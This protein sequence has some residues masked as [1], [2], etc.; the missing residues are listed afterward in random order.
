MFFLQW[1][2]CHRFNV[3]VCVCVCVCMCVRACVQNIDG[4]EDGSSKCQWK[5]LEPLLVLQFQP[6]PLKVTPRKWPLPDLSSCLYTNFHVYGTHIQW[7]CDF[8]V[9]RGMCCIRLVQRY[10]YLWKLA[11]DGNFIYVTFLLLPTWYTN[12]FF[13]YTNYIS[14]RF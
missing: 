6:L 13:I 11:A 5:E 14:N 9:S 12:F 8:S 2:E 7:N 1:Q 3:Y 4:P 10:N